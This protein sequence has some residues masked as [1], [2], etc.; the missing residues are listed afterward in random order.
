MAIY[1]GELHQVY[2]SLFVNF[3]ATLYEKQKKTKNKLHRSS[4]CIIED[5][6]RLLEGHT[7][8]WFLA[9]FCSCI[10]ECHMTRNTCTIKVNNNNSVSHAHKLKVTVSANV[11]K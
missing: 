1:F 8:I 6:A 7:L 2:S 3:D 4:V 9:C 11:Q 10:S 5:A